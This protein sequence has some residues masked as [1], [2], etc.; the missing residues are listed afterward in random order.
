MTNEITA[1]TVS[2]PAGEIEIHEIGAGTPLVCLHGALVSWQIWEPIARPLAMRGYRVIMPSLPLGAHRTAMRPDTDLTPPGL[3]EIIADVIAALDLPTVT[4]LSTDTATALTQLVL[5]LHPGTIDRA[6]MT[7][8]DCFRY[9]FPPLFRP[10]Q[11]L[12]YAPWLLP[13][14][15]GGMKNRKLRE[16]P[17]ALGWLTKAGVSN[18]IAAA[19]GEPIMRDRAVRRDA[20]RV[21][22]GI[23]TRHTMRA[24]KSL[25]DVSVPVMLVWGEI[26]KAFPTK[27]AHRLADLIP[28][29]R[30]ETVPDA[31]CF[32]SLDNP[33]ALVSLIE[34]FV[35]SDPEARAARPTSGPRAAAS[36][37]PAHRD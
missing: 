14:V 15:A 17:L 33:D 36:P 24:A 5:T 29:C 3:A 30:L 34:D 16:S 19:W 22:R 26:D 27:L 13:R 7:S 37:L 8:G 23:N 25:P 28:N 35:P 4:T 12:G 6:V 2:I 1:H 9:F 20:A 18:E 32:V 11:A 10:L 21:L 31:A